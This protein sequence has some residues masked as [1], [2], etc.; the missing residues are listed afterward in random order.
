MGNATATG[1]FHHYEAEL[2]IDRWGMMAGIK[3]AMEEPS[4]GQP[5]IPGGQ[6]DGL[7]LQKSR[8]TLR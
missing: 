7:A 4:P 3:S 6:G 5:L 8:K 2:R 1:L